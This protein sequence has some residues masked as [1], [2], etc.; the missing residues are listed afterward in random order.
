[1]F[2]LTSISIVVLV[3]VFV[4]VMSNEKRMGAIKVQQKNLL[5]PKKNGPI[6]YNDINLA[7]PLVSCKTNFKYSILPETK[8]VSL[9]ISHNLSKQITSSLSSTL[10]ITNNGVIEYFL[11]DLKVWKSSEPRTHYYGV[12]TEVLKNYFAAKSTENWDYCCETSNGIRLHL[13]PLAITCDFGKRIVWSFLSGWD[14]TSFCTTQHCE[15]PFE[16]SH[17]K[18][19]K[20]VNVAI[21]K[22]RSKRMVLLPNADIVT[23]NAGAEKRGGNKF[24]TEIKG[25][26]IQSYC[27]D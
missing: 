20:A 6:S 7:A 4:F 21:S 25:S 9:P 3:V 12:E 1:M 14:A 19:D 18:L 11:N 16:L 17:S 10:L 24:I 8:V 26:L 23:V 22:D 13:A 15:I 27:A 5:A 2:Y